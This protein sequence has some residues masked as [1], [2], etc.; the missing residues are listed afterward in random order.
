[1][2][3]TT[4]PILLYI[5][6]GLSQEQREF[7]II[8]SIRRIFWTPAAFT[9]NEPII[10]TENVQKWYDNAFPVLRGANQTVNRQEVVVIMG[11][12]GSGKSTFIRTFNG[13]ESYQKGRILIDGITVSH[14]L[15]NIEAIRQKVVPSPES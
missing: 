6:L 15:K 5:F 3:S 9:N 14:N 1:V 11:S 2:R 8:G 12:S 10:I 4:S 13:L 7:Y